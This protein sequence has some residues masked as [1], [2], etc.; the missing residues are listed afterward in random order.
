MTRD[1]SRFTVLFFWMDEKVDIVVNAKVNNIG[2]CNGDCEKCDVRKKLCLD[3]KGKL[4]GQAAD[5]VSK[6]SGGFV[7]KGIRCLACSKHCVSCSRVDY[8]QKCGNRKVLK[9][10][11]CVN[12]CGRGMTEKRG[13]CVSD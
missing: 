7:K 11:V 9:G 4:L 5:C 12:D 6:C 2:G 10:K 3:C 1:Y 8:C 13:I